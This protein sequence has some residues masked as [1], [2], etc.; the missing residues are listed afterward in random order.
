MLK[1]ALPS[2]FSTIARVAKTSTRAHPGRR[3][4]GGVTSG[5]WAGATTGNRGLLQLMRT[6]PTGRSDDRRPVARVCSQIARQ[7]AP[8]VIARTVRNGCTPQTMGESS[9]DS[10]IHSAQTLLMVRTMRAI[11]LLDAVVRGRAS[12][13]QQQRAALFVGPG[14]ATGYLQLLRG[15]YGELSR[16][17]PYVCTSQPGACASSPPRWL[18]DPRR[19]FTLEICRG[20]TDLQRAFFHV[21]L[22]RLSWYRGREGC[23]TTYL[24][25]LVWDDPDLGIGACPR[26]WRSPPPSPNPTPP[27]LQ[28]TVTVTVPRES[29]LATQRYVVV[30]SESEPTR[31]AMA[32]VGARGFLQEVF[33]RPVGRSVTWTSIQGQPATPTINYGTRS[34]VILIR[35]HRFRLMSDGT[36]V[37]DD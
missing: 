1:S 29:L 9:P 19:G 30:D 32:T 12:P 31:W 6:A 3:G 4:E 37:K 8:V 25:A 22:L 24:E 36:V 17:V 23:K 15:L 13:A 10:T 16:I 34:E 33:L 26:P 27:N 20:D 2:R 7:R 28:P 14:D 35:G 21:A 18:F 5:F 11:E